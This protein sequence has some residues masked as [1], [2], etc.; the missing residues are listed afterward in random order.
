[1]AHAIHDESILHMG[2]PF[3]NG[4]LAMWIFLST[5]V[6]F[7]T[8][9]IGMYIVLRNG[10]PTDQYP[11]PAPHQVHLVEWIGAVNTF[12]LICSSVTVVLAHLALTRGQ[13][14]RAAQY[15]GVSLALG[16]VFLGI[17]AYEYNSKY[18]HG[19]LPGWVYDNVEG[20]RGTEYM[21]RIR[22]D[23]KHLESNHYSIDPEVAELCSKLAKDLELK[24]GHAFIAPAA[25][26]DRVDKILKT[27][28][29]KGQEI[30]LTPVIPFGNMWASCYFAMTGFHALHVLGGLVV[31]VIILVI[32][33]GRGLGYQHADMLE[34]TGLY[35]HFVDIVWIFLFPLLYLI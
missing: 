35:W 26:R 7:F 8:G 21:I 2:A 6:M 34:I 11:W 3:H 13:F 5:E 9:L 33:V 16:L 12:V 29:E 17:K 4:K 32:A 15:I 22:E 27:A 14:Q 25:V 23:L 30:H 28:E 24:D 18:Q 31:F 10:T 19:V 20:K 1:M